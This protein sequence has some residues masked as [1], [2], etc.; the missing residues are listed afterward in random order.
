MGGPGDSGHPV[1]QQLIGGSMSRNPDEA[2]LAQWDAERRANRR[3]WHQEIER[4]TAACGD[5]VVKV[6]V[7]AE[8]ALATPNFDGPSSPRTEC[9]C[10]NRKNESTYHGKGWDGR[11]GAETRGIRRRWAVPSAKKMGLPLRGAVFDGRL[12]TPQ[13][14]SKL[15]RCEGD[16]LIASGGLP[17][18]YEAFARNS[19]DWGQVVTYEQGYAWVLVGEG[20]NFRLNVLSSAANVVSLAGL[21]SYCGYPILAQVAGKL[22]K[23]SYSCEGELLVVEFLY[24]LFVKRVLAAS[25]ALGLRSILAG[26]YKVEI[27][28]PSLARMS[29]ADMELAWWGGVWAKDGAVANLVEANGISLR[30]VGLSFKEL[31]PRP[32]IIYP[33]PDTPTEIVTATLRSCEGAGTIVVETLSDFVEWVWESAE[34]VSVDSSPTFVGPTSCDSVRLLYLVHKEA[35]S[36]WSD[37]ATWIEELCEQ[38]HCEDDPDANVTDTDA[39]TDVAP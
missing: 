17:K 18:F 31:Q 23:A 20:R 14:A 39:A 10:R 32:G 28:I 6:G 9:D 36:L 4:M 19:V 25:P 38:A 30:R 3:A 29:S 5:A 27:T 16:Q 34:S 15:A 24:K 26:E 21:Q 8:S 7:D 35:H 33:T 13:A 12:F 37:V 11:T 1:L 22:V 2:M